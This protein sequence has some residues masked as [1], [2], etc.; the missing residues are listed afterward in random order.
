MTLLD[1]LQ[2]GGGSLDAL[3]RH[4]VAALLNSTS[5][6]VDYAY[7]EAEIIQMFQDVYPGTDAEY[8]ALKG[9]LDVE[10]ERGCET[11]DPT[12]TAAGAI[13]GPGG[14]PNTGG[15]GPSSSSS[16]LT[17]VVIGLVAAAVG[18]WWAVRPASR[19]S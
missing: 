4:L 12:P 14:L 1:A 11:P 17:L 3:G 19:R 16:G 18:A 7:T 9:I 8:E 10:N 15:L 2:D 5:P 6:T 13:Q